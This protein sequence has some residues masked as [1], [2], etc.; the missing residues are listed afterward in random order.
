MSQVSPTYLRA[1]ASSEA[2]LLSNRHRHLRWGLDHLP[3]P[4]P[5]T[6]GS[7]LGEGTRQWAR[8]E[9]LGNKRAP[10]SS[11]GRK[12]TCLSLERSTPN[13]EVSEEYDCSRLQVIDDRRV[14]GELVG[15]ESDRTS[16]A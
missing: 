4:N 3:E 7:V 5:W 2:R 11:R 1:Y 9:G 15:W 6:H 13:I 16:Q 12:R 10:R 8:E 14:L